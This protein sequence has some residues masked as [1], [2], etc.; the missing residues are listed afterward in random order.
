MW[1]ISNDKGTYMGKLMK[2]GKRTVRI[3]M[4]RIMFDG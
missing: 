2:V 4:A 3:G 1:G